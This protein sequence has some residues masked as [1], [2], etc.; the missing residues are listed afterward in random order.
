MIICVDLD[1]TLLRNDKTLSEYTI[2]TFNKLYLQNYTV[3][4]NSARSFERS[5]TY[6]EMIKAK[7]IICNGGSQI[8]DEKGKCI[9]FK[10]IEGNI[11]KKVINKFKDYSEIIGIQ[12]KNEY[13]SFETKD[14]LNFNRPAYKITIFKGQKTKID[15]ICLNYNLKYVVYENGAWGKVSL[16]EITKYSGLKKLLA[17]INEKEDN[18]WYFGDDIGDLECLLKCGRGI[19]M[20]NSVEEVLKT[21]DLIICDDNENDGVA[22]YINETLL[23]EEM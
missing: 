7:Y 11:V 22:K 23:Y 3:V 20:K 18:V 17:M 8:F 14:Q 15:E 1:S 4:V 21:K 5:K 12:T 16:K 9:F 10:A 19:A 13:Y 2:N 6:S